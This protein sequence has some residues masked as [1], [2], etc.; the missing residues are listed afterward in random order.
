[1]WFM[2]NHFLPLIVRTCAPKYSNTYR[3]RKQ[4]ESI[5]FQFLILIFD[6]ADYLSV[7]DR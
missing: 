3:I 2:E 6:V 7:L 5:I 1:M 4:E